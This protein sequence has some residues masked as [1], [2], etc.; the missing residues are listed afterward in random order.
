MSD[1]KITVGVAGAQEAASQLNAVGTSAGVADQKIGHMGRSAMGGAHLLHGLKAAAEGSSQG[2]MGAASGAAHL[3]ES[4]GG[5]GFAAATLALGGIA[6]AVSIV[7]NWLQKA[8]EAAEK[9]KEKIEKAKERQAELTEMRMDRAIKEYDKLTAAIT[10]S[11]AAQEKLNKAREKL[12]SA[13][14]Q[15]GLARLDLEE[16]QKRRQLAPDDE[17]GRKRLELEY[18]GKREDLRDARAQSEASAKIVEAQQRTAAVIELAHVEHQKF[19]DAATIA[20]DKQEELNAL[21]K[22][23]I[24]ALNRV[25]EDE[26]QIDQI[27]R[28]RRANEITRGQALGMTMSLERDRDA[29]KKEADDLDQKV[30]RATDAAV[31]ARDVRD[32]ALA[33]SSRAYSEVYPSKINEQVAA[34]EARAAA[35]KTQTSP[36]KQADAIAIEQNREDARRAAEDERARKEREEEEREAKVRQLEAIKEETTL[37]ERQTQDRLRLLTHGQDPA[38]IEAVRA[39]AG[40]RTQ[41]EQ[42][43][44][45]KLSREVEQLPSNLTAY[46][47]SLHQTMRNLNDKLRDTRSRQDSTITN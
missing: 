34:E 11:A 15:T 22:K 4:M 43:A 6:A 13:K 19:L 24:D 5:P 39:Q 17:E 20:R 37:R 7:A 32:A 18:A 42:A 16:A 36:L 2:M 3:A 30:G 23:R 45:L 26:K 21:T 25:S 46:L 38:Q 40:A 31:K 44:A 10:E 33:S 47:D 12:E 29:A 35:V 8:H 27:A 41:S 14:V 28:A 9:L 1:V